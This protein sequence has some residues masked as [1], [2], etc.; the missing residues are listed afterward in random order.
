MSFAKQIQR[1]KR[2]ALKM[3]VHEKKD[4][5]EVVNYGIKAEQSG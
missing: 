4:A 3:G 1:S 5:V 2:G